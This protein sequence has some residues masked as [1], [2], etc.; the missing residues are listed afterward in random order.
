MVEEKEV[1]VAQGQELANQIS[2]Q[3]SEISA[4]EG[5]GISELFE[6]IAKAL[7]KRDTDMLSEGV[8]K[9]ALRN[10]KLGK[11]GKNKTGKC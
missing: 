4:K 3:F 11:N 8:D 2:A 10:T 6:E 1:S 5:T 7:Y 9:E